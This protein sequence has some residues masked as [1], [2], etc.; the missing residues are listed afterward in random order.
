MQSRTNRRNKRKIGELRQTLAKIDQ[1]LSSLRRF[2]RT[3]QTE[4]H[5]R[6]LQ[7]ERSYVKQQIRKLESVVVG[8]PKKRTAEE[9]N[10]S[11]SIKNKRNWQFVSSIS[12]NY[13]IPK[14][15]VRAE[16]KKKKKGLES[17]IDDVIWRNPSP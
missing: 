2:R 16:Y 6:H 5:E 14:K 10:R 11:R 12:I 3:P 17:D 9:A 1:E 15:K 13:G 7:G 8:R 4:K